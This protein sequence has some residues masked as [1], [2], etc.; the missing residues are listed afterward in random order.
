MLLWHFSPSSY[1]MLVG[2]H[3]WIN[4][5]TRRY[6]YTRVL[7]SK[8]DPWPA[9]EVSKRTSQNFKKDVLY[10]QISS[11]CSS[12]WRIVSLL[13]IIINCFVYFISRILF[14]E[15]ELFVVRWMDLESVIQS[16][17]S[18]KEKNKYC[19]L[20]HIYGTKKKKKWFWRT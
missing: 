11:L 17:V 5:P 15:I 20:T 6:F 16:E 3:L 1:N 10:S 9:Q 18:Q 4:R 8:Q 19:M 7:G 2:S 14:P 12:Y 13:R